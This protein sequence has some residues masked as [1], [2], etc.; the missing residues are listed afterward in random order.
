LVQVLSDQ[1]LALRT[2]KQM[3]YKWNQ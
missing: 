1:E 3:E 2:A